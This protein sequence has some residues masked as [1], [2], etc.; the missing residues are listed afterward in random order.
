METLIAVI[1]LF[2]FGMILLYIATA[3]RDYTGKFDDEI[4]DPSVKVMGACSRCLKHSELVIF[5]YLD[6]EDGYYLCAE[7]DE[8]D[9]IEPV[10]A[11]MIREASERIKRNDRR[12]M[13][14]GMCGL[15]GEVEDLS[16]GV[17]RRAGQDVAICAKCHRKE[18]PDA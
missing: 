5:K 3:P 8:L 14:I 17:A 18:Y 10:T 12:P 2:C 6:T 4:S 9:D 15:C 1:G 11:D 13:H 7:C 16:A